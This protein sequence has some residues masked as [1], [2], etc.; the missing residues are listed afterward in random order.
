MS[1]IINKHPG[2]TAE[3]KETQ[4]PPRYSDA[5]LAKICEK[6]QI[7]RPATFKGVID[8]LKARKYI[9]QEKKSFNPT[10]V[11]MKVVEFLRQ[12][13]M[14]FIDIKFTAKMEELLDD[15]QS[16]T[17][18]K[19][20][21]L[22]KFWER[23]QKDIANG[24]QIKS[25]GEVSEYKCPKCGGSLLKK[26]SKF[27]PFF[28][29]QNSKKLTQKQ[30]DAGEESPCDYIASVGKSGEPLTKQKVEKEYASFPC[31]KCGEKMVKRHSK[32]GSFFGCE[33]FP[34]CKTT[35][36]L[37]GNFKESSGKKF[38]KYKKYKKKADDE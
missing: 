24:K 30:I 16:G 6:E 3:R 17:K 14:C 38:K 26:F 23:L 10:E 1:D 22:D 4:P 31:K 33:K 13:D 2:L 19:I 8:T 36:D 18:D 11:G 29:C 21:V 37:E 7:T 35:A 25:A 9:T 32:F 5:S 12:A 15:V 27:G 20:E 34:S 28:A